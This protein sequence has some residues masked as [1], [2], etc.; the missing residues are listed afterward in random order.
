MID[1]KILT[2]KL[3]DFGINYQIKVN[4][5]YIDFIERQLNS[6]GFTNADFVN[7][8]DKIM[9]T[10]TTTFNKMPNLAMFLEH[11]TK[12]PPSVETIAH[13][14]ASQVFGWL[15]ANVEFWRNDYGD[16][17]EHL[18]ENQDYGHE[19]EEDLQYVV[20]REF[21]N[22]SGLIKAYGEAYLSGFSNLFKKDL[23]GAFKVQGSM[24][25]SGLVAIESEK[26]KR[27]DREDEI[28]DY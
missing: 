26:L 13:D 19:F 15:V 11:S 23:I 17:K 28:T 18:R 16:G 25:Q 2:M 8:I 7:S 3:R 9:E 14:K 5:D 22:T 6:K 10:N 24:L 4:A 21:G 1:K 27:E 20:D 12:K